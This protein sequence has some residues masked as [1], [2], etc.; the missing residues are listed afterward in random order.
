MCGIVGIQGLQEDASIIAMNEQIVH[1]G[2]D[3]EG[4]FRHRDNH[5]SLAMRRL[6]IIDLAGGVQP[7]STPDG[8]YT[9]VFNGEIFNA[10]DLRKE[11][12]NKG[13]AF[14]T[15]HSDTEV[16][17]NYYALEG[18]A[19]VERLNGMFALA[20]YDRAKKTLF[21]A[22]DRAGIKPFYY[23]DDGRRFAFASELKSILALPGFAR[24]VDRQSLF[25]YISLMYVPSQ[26]TAI[27]GVRRLGPGQSLTFHFS[28]RRLEVKS[29]WRLSFNEDK[30]LSVGQWRE[31]LR[32]TLSAATDRWT[33]A[34]VPYGCLLS[35]GLDSSAI[36]GLLA[37]RGADIK[38]FSLGFSG[39]GEEQWSELP[40]ARSMA[41]KWGTEHHQI[42][43]DPQ[44]LLDDLGSMVWHMDEPYGGG[45]PSWSVFKF[46]G[47]HVK[48]ALTGTGGDELFGN[49]NKF[50]GLERRFLPGL[51]AGTHAPSEDRFRR[52][53][54]DRHYYCSDA[55]K[56]RH[57]FA[58]DCTGLIDTSALLYGHLAA[59]ESEALR[60]RTTRVDFETQLPEEFLAMTDRFSMAHH[61]EARTPFL[62][63]HMIDLAMSVPPSL[64]LNPRR[65]KQLLRDTIGDLLPPDVVDAPKRGFVV[66]LK[67]WLRDQLRPL[68]KHLLNPHRLAAQGIFRPAF[69]DHTVRP[70]LDGE[71][72][73]TT[74]VWGALMFQIWHQVFIEQPSPQ[75][76]TWDLKA[77]G[78]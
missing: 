75:A 77:I 32:A 27:E 26:R 61:V 1:R 22:R 5:L 24:R 51:S 33:L 13:M 4:V 36:V 48:V 67:L 11:L 69:Y 45:L 34:D 58:G 9:I 15:D 63:N 76:P 72:D 54:S 17:L 41:D 16:V 3:G 43:L 38:T 39:P 10:P 19:M 12:E 73:N 56:R 68:V 7:M 47:D 50:S 49:Y 70:H 59:Q 23:C 6:A 2:P 18:P 78:A 42:I 20:I 46:L 28:D 35:G 30:S 21:C 55:D 31:R 37:E 64:R 53:F 14:Q 44:S 40:L 52:G 25:H 66:P 57:V 74:L 29:W 8:L 65:Y 60:N 62:D 71:A